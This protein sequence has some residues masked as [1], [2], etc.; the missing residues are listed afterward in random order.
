[1]LAV[2]APYDVLASGNLLEVSFN[3]HDERHLCPWFRSSDYAQ[4]TDC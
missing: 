3:W 1:M 4:F 2:F